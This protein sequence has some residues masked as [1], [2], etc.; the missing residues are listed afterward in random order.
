MA[1]CDIQ[2]GVTLK[3][4]LTLFECVTPPV[5]PKVPIDLSSQT[6]MDIILL[7]PGAVRIVTAAAFVTDGTDGKMTGIVPAGPITVSGKW[8]VQ[9]IATVTAGEVKS[10]VKNFDV[11]DNI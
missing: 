1:S 7:G 3:I 10:L 6:S 8:S 5:T 4:T 9:G 2:V 11:R